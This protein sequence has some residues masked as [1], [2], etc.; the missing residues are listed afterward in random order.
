MAVGG[1]GG[2]GTSQAEELH[3]HLDMGME[4]RHF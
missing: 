1:G 4:S 2:T 3:D